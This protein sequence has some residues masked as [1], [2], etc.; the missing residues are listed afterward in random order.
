MDDL[1]APPIVEGIRPGSPAQKAGLKTGDLILSIGNRR[2][3]AYSEVVDAFFYL[4][5]GESQIF[6]VLRGVEIKEIKITPEARPR[7]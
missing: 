1:V 2:V 4:I 3:S 5:A 6:K 7:G